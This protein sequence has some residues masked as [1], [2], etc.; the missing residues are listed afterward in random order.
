M[1]I[2]NRTRM[3]IWT[4]YVQS[5]LVT[6]FISTLK[7]EFKSHRNADGRKETRQYSR[8]GWRL[9][10]TVK[11]SFGAREEPR[12]PRAQPRL[13]GV[14]DCSQFTHFQLEISSRRE[15]RSI[16]YTIILVTTARGWCEQPSNILTPLRVQLYVFNP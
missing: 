16:N 15:T 6:T 9:P 7:Y 10:E 14:S 5:V 2:W 4:A 1:P 8:H 3:T 13:P 11:Q 12:K